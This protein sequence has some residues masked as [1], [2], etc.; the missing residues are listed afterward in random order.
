ML[1]SSSIFSLWICLILNSIIGLLIPARATTS[2]FSFFLSSYCILIILQIHTSTASSFFLVAFVWS[3][4]HIYLKVLTIHSN[5]VRIFSFAL[6]D[7]LVFLLVIKLDPSF[8]KNHS[9]LDLYIVPTICCSYIARI[10][11]IFYLFGDLPTSFKS[12]RGNF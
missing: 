12:A 9:F 5:S 6:T 10:F 1:R 2:S 7:V 8:C 3:G 11:E 4:T